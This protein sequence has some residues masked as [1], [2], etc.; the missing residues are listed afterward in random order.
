MGAQPGTAA[1]KAAQEKRD[2]YS[3]SYENVEAHVVPLAFETSGA[4]D[5][6]ALKAL[7]AWASKARKTSRCT[8]LHDHR[9]RPLLERL[10]VRLHSHVAAT[11][12]AYLRKYGARVGVAANVG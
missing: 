3:R 12:T 7:K 1:A 11:H 6:E 10:A 5:K 9:L 2:K 4:P 8:E